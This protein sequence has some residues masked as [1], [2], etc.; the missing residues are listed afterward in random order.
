MRPNFVSV[1]VWSLAATSNLIF[2]CGDAWVPFKVQDPIM[3]G[4]EQLSLKGLGVEVV[5]RQFS[6]TVVNG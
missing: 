5:H 1:H 3:E 2:C 4:P 6:G